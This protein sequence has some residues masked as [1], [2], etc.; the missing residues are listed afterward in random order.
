VP[1][2]IAPGFVDPKILPKILPMSLRLI[3]NNCSIH[4]ERRSKIRKKFEMNRHIT[5]VEEIV[6]ISRSLPR[7]T[8]L[9]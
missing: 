2:P 4:T 3:G 8:S 1:K 7:L 6:S 9:H 5:C